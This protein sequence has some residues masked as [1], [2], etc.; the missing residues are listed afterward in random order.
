MVGVDLHEHRVPHGGVGKRLAVDVVGRKACLIYAEADGDCRNRCDDTD[1]DGLFALGLH[2]RFVCF[3]QLLSD[4]LGRSGFGRDIRRN[5][6]SFG[7]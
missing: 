1:D 3:N 7:V 2:C 6:A 4:G 5:I